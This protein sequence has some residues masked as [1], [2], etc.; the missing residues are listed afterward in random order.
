MLTKRA[1]LICIE[2]VLVV[3]V[4]GCGAPKFYST[5]GG[6]YQNCKLYA[7][8]GKDIDAVYQ[9]TLQAMDKLQ[10]KVTD[11]AKDVF[12]AKVMAKSADNELIVVKIKPT[13]DQKTAYDIQVGAFGNEERSRKI[14]TEIENALTAGKK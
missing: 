10:L 8:S 4:V 13:A 6:V 12:A 11:K 7:V 2:A 9:A 14:F 5:E 3:G 1:L